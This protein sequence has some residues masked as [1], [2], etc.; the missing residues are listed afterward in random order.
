M[1]R[2]G[3]HAAGE[4]ADFGRLRVNP[5]VIDARANL[6]GVCRRWYPNSLELHRF[7]IA[8]SRVV[9]NHDN[10]EG[11]APDPLVWSASAL[12]KRRRLVHAVRNCAL[13]PGTASIWTSDRVSFLPSVF[14][15]EDVCAWPY[16]VG[17]LVKWITFLGTLHWPAAGADVGV[18]GGSYEEMLPLYELWAGERLVLAKLF[19]SEG[20]LDAQI[21]CRLFLLVQALILSD[22]ARSLGL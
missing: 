1:D 14:T 22:N 7:F 9:V 8:I 19:P 4:A 15:A 3:N 18:G 12:P 17:I 11:T 6:S 20:D 13:L 10:R 16:S 21:Q 2:L 5:G